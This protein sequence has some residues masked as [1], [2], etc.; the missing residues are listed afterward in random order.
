MAE[1]LI[2]T[3]LIRIFSAHSKL[4]RTFPIFIRKKS[5]RKN[6]TKFHLE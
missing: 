1:K 4:D 5:K 2:L 3:F 6:C